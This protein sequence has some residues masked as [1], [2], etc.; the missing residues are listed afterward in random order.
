M[1]LVVW[2]ALDG[3]AVASCWVRSQVMGRM[4]W[5][6]WPVGQQMTVSATVLVE[7]LP[8]EVHVVSEGQQKELGKPVP[9]CESELSPP[10]VSARG[11]SPTAWA[12][13]SAMA[14]AEA[15]GTV[16]D[17]RHT[18]DSFWKVEG[19]MFGDEDDED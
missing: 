16:V 9:Q 10:Q 7:L 6:F 4:Y 19:P 1:R 11:S 3:W 5:Q 14:R 15:A 13:P 18:T 17:S 12:A 8:M 2:M